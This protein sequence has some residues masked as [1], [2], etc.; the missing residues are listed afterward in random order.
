[1]TIST[2]TVAGMTCGHCVNAVSSEISKVARVT[3]VT[4]DLNSGVVT[5]TSDGPVDRDAIVAAVDE[6]GYEVVPAA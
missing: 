5:V 6:A 1:M 4:V 3:D 2:Y